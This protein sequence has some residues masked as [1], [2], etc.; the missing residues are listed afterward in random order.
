MSITSKS[1]RVVDETFSHQPSSCRRRSAAGPGKKQR[2][3]DRAGSVVDDLHLV[4]GRCENP[5]VKLS[6]VE[7]LQFRQ[8]LRGS[9]F[10]IAESC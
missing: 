1:Q 9:V 8:T 7:N 10:T 6:D 4:A 2:G 3:N 5:S